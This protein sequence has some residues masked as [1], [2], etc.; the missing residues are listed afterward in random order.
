MDIGKRI[1]IAVDGLRQ[2]R[3]AA[4]I[5][6]PFLSVRFDDTPKISLGILTIATILDSMKIEYCFSKPD[7]SGDVGYLGN[8]TS[9]VCYSA[10][11]CSF[12]YIKN[13]ISSINDRLNKPL[14]LVGGALPTSLPDEWLKIPGVD[15]VFLG[16]ADVSLQ[17]LLKD[18][19]FQNMSGVAYRNNGMEIYQS[20]K[21]PL[22]HE[23]VY[24]D[25]GIL[26]S[27][28]PRENIIQVQVGRGCNYACKIC[29]NRSGYVRANID[30]FDKCYKRVL[31]AGHGSI[32]FVD[33]DLFSSSIDEVLQ[34]LS[35]YRS[36]IEW[37]CS[38]KC[39]INQCQKYLEHMVELGCNKISVDM[40]HVSGCIH[41]V[42]NLFAKRYVHEDTNYYVRLIQLIRSYG[43]EPTVAFHLGLYGETDDTI[44]EAKKFFDATEVGVYDIRPYVYPGSKYFEMTL[45]KGKQSGIF[46]SKDDYMDKLDN[47]IKSRDSI[48]GEVAELL[49]VFNLSEVK[50]DKLIDAIE[51][52][53]NLSVYQ[54]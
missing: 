28:Y 37:S 15:M 4:L 31:N 18:D 44:D 12:K 47:Y 45:N 52:L 39:D 11:I 13:H 8:D 43:I 30:R 48:D 10:D 35:K 24:P 21:L 27:E 6:P 23:I 46:G 14:I 5:V 7:N 36:S 16:E 54:T 26:Y 41:S 38:V 19:S 49:D 34:I 25:Y 29:S 20:P 51:Y 40:Q 1:K 32:T 9:I 42:N 17:A 53:S 22:S 50:T 33:N 2:G 3:K